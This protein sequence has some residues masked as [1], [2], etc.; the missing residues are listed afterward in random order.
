MTERTCVFRLST[1]DLACRAVSAAMFFSSGVRRDVR[2]VLLLGPEGRS[3]SGRERGDAG[4]ADAGEGTARQRETAQKRGQVGPRAVW[5]SGSSVRHL[6]PDERNIAC[7]LQTAV[8]AYSGRINALSRRV[9]GSRRP[10][11]MPTDVSVP[12]A[13]KQHYK[14]TSRGYQDS[15]K[16]AADR[17][18]E[19]D[20]PA[21]PAAQTGNTGAERAQA[22]LAPALAPAPLQIKGGAEHGTGASGAFEHAVGA[23]GVLEIPGNVR[24]LLGEDYLRCLKGW[25]V[26]NQGLAAV[27]NL[28]MSAPSHAGS[29]P[30]AFAASSPRT[31]PRSPPPSEPAAQ[32]HGGSAQGQ[33]GGDSPSLSSLSAPPPHHAPS[34]HIPHT[35]AHEIGCSAAETR[36]AVEGECGGGE[37]KKEGTVQ[38]VLLQL[39]EEG[40]F[41]AQVF[42][43]SAPLRPRLLA[44]STV[45]ALRLVARSIHSIRLCA[46]LCLC[47]CL[48]ACV[49]LDQSRTRSTSLA[50]ALLP[51]PPVLSSLPPPSSILRLIPTTRRLGRVKTC[52]KCM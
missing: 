50:S 51:L 2:V 20:R 37:N 27:L 48:S 18:D 44:R 5:I 9:E 41:V 28:C 24:E 35:M 10:G 11:R 16:L 13:Q 22:A 12:G 25:R 30:S 38:R 29:E 39:D 40:E 1:A 47:L 21:A 19:Q 45:C 8:W 3:G 42:E 4:D 43:R 23:G 36:P 15:R 33:A 49:S 52:N 17:G 31:A 34:S 32:G 26:S 46:S 14:P 7:V 6:R